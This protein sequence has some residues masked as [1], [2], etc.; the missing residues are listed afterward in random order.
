M[1]KVV[2]VEWKKGNTIFNLENGGLINWF[3]PHWDKNEMKSNVEEMNDDITNN[4]PITL[5]E[6]GSINWDGL[7]M[8]E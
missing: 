5:L 6:D 2:K 7:I 1:K 8:F 4:V 3:N